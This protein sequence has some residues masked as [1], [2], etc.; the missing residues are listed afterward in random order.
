MGHSQGGLITS[1]ALNDVYRRLRIEDG[2]STADVERTMGRINVET[3]GAA[4]TTYPNGPNYVHY[5]NNND[6]VPTLFGQGNGQGVDEF[7]RKAGR[8]AVVHRFEQ[9][10]GIEGTHSF[11]SVYLNRR[12][13]FEQARQNQF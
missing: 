8:G 13:P 12:V 9:G 11:D 3:F 5:V 6:L 10:S 2:M 4:A 1:R 7:V